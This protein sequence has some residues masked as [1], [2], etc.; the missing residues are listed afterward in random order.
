[1]AEQVTESEPLLVCVNGFLLTSLNLITFVIC[2]Q[3]EKAFLKQPKVF[4]WYVLIFFFILFSPAADVHNRDLSAFFL[5]WIFLLNNFWMYF[6]NCS[7]KKSGK[8]K[9]PGKGGN[10]YFKS[11]GLGFKTPREAIEGNN[12]LLVVVAPSFSYYLLII[13]S[14]CL[15]LHDILFNTLSFSLY[16]Y[17]YDTWWILGSS[18]SFCK[19]SSKLSQIYML[20]HVYYDFFVCVFSP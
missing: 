20:H 15:K 19:F 10:R 13:L 7:S 18:H 12:R 9:R 3:T 16:M 11:I 6:G 2:V 17:I 14:I 4:L 5:L 1:M 8:G